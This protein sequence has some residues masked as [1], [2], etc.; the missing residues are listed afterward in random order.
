M[1]KKSNLFQSGEPLTEKQ[2]EE[3]RN[4]VKEKE[5]EL[6]QLEKNLEKM[7]EKGTGIPLRMPR[8]RPMPQPRP[9]PKP[10]PKPL[11]RSKPLPKPKRRQRQRPT[12][13]PWLLPIPT[14][15]AYGG[16]KVVYR[17]INGKVLDGNE[18]TGMIY[19]ND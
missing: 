4:R 7:R 13:P 9:M 3:F 15:M 16:G 17:K 18:I 8:Q 12:T 2:L 19:K 1:G 10:K 5:N 6:K 11:P 14:Q